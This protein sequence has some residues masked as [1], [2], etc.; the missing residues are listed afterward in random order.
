MKGTI[1]PSFDSLDHSKINV[2]LYDE[3]GSIIPSE[4]RVNKKSGKF[5]AFFP[6][7]INYKISYDLGKYGKGYDTVMSAN[8]KMYREIIKDIDLAEPN[9]F[10][11]R[12]KKVLAQNDVF[13]VNK[14]I[15]LRLPVLKNDESVAASLIPQSFQLLK[16]PLFGKVSRDSLGA[17][18]YTPDHDYVGLDSFSYCVKNNKNIVSN[19]AMVSLNIIGEG[20]KTYLY[21]EKYFE[22]KINHI[23]DSRA[24]KKFVD[25]VLKEI[26][27]SGIVYL[28]I[29]SSAS[30]VP[31]ALGSNESLAEKRATDA[32]QKLKTAVIKQKGDWT[33]V[34]LR[35]LSSIVQ[36]PE[37]TGNNKDKSK[38]AIYQY[39]KISRE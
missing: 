12:W 15:P 2:T 25:D 6:Q 35:P 9:P 26:K 33:K 31:I 14:N 3:S 28:K 18:T 37:Y 30:K 4:I 24:W 20:D 8:E 5:L 11:P 19:E 29:E 7:G 13:D 10:L 22:Y 32:L 38:Y 1:Y 39:V 16:Q 34:K 21:Y 17:I 27:D 36:G 23:E